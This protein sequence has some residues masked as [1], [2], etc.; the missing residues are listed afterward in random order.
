MTRTLPTLLHTRDAGGALAHSGM[1]QGVVAAADELHVA[2]PAVSQGIPRN[3]DLN[4]AVQ[5]GI[6]LMQLNQ[7]HRQRWSSAD[8]F[9]SKAVKA[10]PNLRI[11]LHA[12]TKRVLL[13]GKRAVGVEYH[14]G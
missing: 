11:T 12:T 14:Q 5:E 4:G 3:D 9:L 2:Q 13:E 6:G 7:K 8:A 10:R 1:P